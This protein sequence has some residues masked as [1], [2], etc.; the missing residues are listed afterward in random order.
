MLMSTPPSSSGFPGHTADSLDTYV[1]S[2]VDSD[3]KGQHDRF[4]ARFGSHSVEKHRAEM[5]LM[6]KPYTD[7]TPG[8]QQSMSKRLLRTMGKVRGFMT[9]SFPAD[10]LPVPERQKASLPAPAW[11]QSLSENKV[12]LFVPDKALL[13]NMDNGYEGY[14]R[15]G[16]EVLFNGGVPDIFDIAQLDRRQTCFL[17]SAL[18]AY[19]T[20]PLGNSLL[21]QAIKLYPDDGVV[22]VTLNDGSMAERDVKVLVSSRRPVDDKGKD[23]YSFGNNS[24]AYWPGYFEKACHALLLERTANIEKMK[25]ENPGEDLSYLD[26]LLRLLTSN[27]KSGCMI[28]RVDMSM[29]ISLLPAM[30]KLQSPNP[31][32]QQGKEPEAYNAR[33]NELKEP[34]VK[35]LICFNIKQGIPVILG[36]RGDWK[37]RLNATSG[38]PTDHAVAVLGPA[39]VRK[40]SKTEEGFLIYDPYGEALNQQGASSGSEVASASTVK[41][42]GQAVRFCTY[43]EMH[44]QFARVTIARGCF[45]HN[46]AYLDQLA[47]S[48]PGTS[49]DD[50]GWELV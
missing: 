2:D 39:M 4:K 21:Q 42:A 3:T 5:G 41:A 20:T 46:Q 14:T 47:A 23:Y 26:G 17:L 38:T 13:D 35:D 48:K 6:L 40:G 9:R 7:K 1:V 50:S 11:K 32:F 29:A 28:D 43:D 45:T 19:A 22:G 24:G 12:D 16:K 37:G 18:G 8:S 34:L 33:D 25:S 15:Q 31:A 49:S 44:K 10:R 27:Q 30:P 36:T